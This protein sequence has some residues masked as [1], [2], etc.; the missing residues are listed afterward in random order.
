MTY[1]M[2]IDERTTQGQ[3]LLTYLEM[4]KINV[5]K[6]STPKPRRGSLEQ[7]LDDIKHGRVETFSSAD[8]MCQALGI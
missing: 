8:E 6:V 4:L 5:Q 1:M 7:S 2:T 3:A